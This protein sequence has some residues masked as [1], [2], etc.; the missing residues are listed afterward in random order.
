MISFSS[1]CNSCNCR[2]YFIHYLLFFFDSNVYNIPPT[3]Q[4]I[5]ENFFLSKA[6]TKS[7]WISLFHFLITF[8]EAFPLSSK[9]WKREL[10]NLYAAQ[11][12]AERLVHLLSEW[13]ISH[14]CSVTNFKTGTMEWSKDHMLIKGTGI[15]IV[16]LEKTRETQH[17]NL[18]KIFSKV[19]TIS[20]W[21]R[22]RNTV[23]RW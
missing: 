3:S 2:P 8:L 10:R 23:F 4:P 20:Q 17:L 14:F 22:R 18:G 9:S 21:L 1:S 15:R 12:W 19:F 16:T 6:G 7:L 13:I 11:K 5:W